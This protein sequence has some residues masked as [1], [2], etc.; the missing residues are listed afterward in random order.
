MQTATATAIAMREGDRAGLERARKC[1]PGGWWRPESLVLCTVASASFFGIACGG[2]ASDPGDLEATSDELASVTNGS[3]RNA[4][5]KCVDVHAGCMNANGC[6]VQVWDCNNAPQQ[7]WTVANGQI[8]N[9]NGKCLDVHAGCMNSNGCNVQ[10][11]DCNNASQQTWTASNG[12]IRNANGKCLGV[13]AGC[14]N[15]NG[16]NIQVWDC[17]NASQQTWS[18]SNSGSGVIEA[19]PADI[20]DGQT[21]VVVAHSD[22]EAIWFQP[23]LARARAVVQVAGGAAPAQRVAQ[24]L[25]YGAAYERNR[26]Q[27]VYPNYATNDAW[28]QDFGLRDRCERDQIYTVAAFRARLEPYFANPANRRFLTHN[29]WGEYGHTHHRMVGEAVR[30]LAVQYRKEV[31]MLSMQRQSYSA[32]DPRGTLYRNLGDLAGLPSVNASFDHATF[33]HIRGSFQSQFFQ[34]GTDTW[35][36]HDGALDYPHG[37]RTYV[38]IVDANQGDLTGRNWQRAA[39]INSVVADTALSGG[40]GTP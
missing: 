28:I 34:P 14:M 13:H 31:W 7:T 24:R 2:M 21:V 27:H 12:Q 3:I 38:K 15:S 18:A 36:W 1:S 39:I 25:A 8:R 29:H 35:T 10:V 33:R 23:F 30:Q 40:C 9:A 32:D 16:C 22:D 26:I 20:N 5:G 19:P 11:W 4:N 17:N 37:T 6:N